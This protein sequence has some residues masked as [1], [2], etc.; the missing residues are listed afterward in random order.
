MREKR[1]KE[2][3]GEKGERINEEKIMKIINSEVVKEKMNIYRLL[4]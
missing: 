4:E 2:K 3:R 1:R